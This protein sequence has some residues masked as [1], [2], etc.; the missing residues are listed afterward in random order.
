AGPLAVGYLLWEIALSKAKVH[1]LS[2]LAAT[3][4]VL[5]TFLLCL[6]L[7]TLPGP[8]LIIAALLVGGGV[9]LSA[10]E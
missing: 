3:T 6:F 4:P 1:T 10:R 2:L 5:S 9:L 8:E 7:R